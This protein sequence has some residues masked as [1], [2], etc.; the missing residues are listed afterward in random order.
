[1]Y[2]GMCSRV[3]HQFGLLTDAMKEK[4]IYDDSAIFFFS[5]HG[6]YTGDYGIVEKSQNSF[7][8]SISSV[9]FII[10]PPSVYKVS[11]RVTDALAELIDFSATVFEMTGIDPGYDS[12]GRSLLP[13][14]AGDT[15]V[16]REAVF[17]EEGAD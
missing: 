8:D 5:D 16:H 3:D 1:M 14:I 7:E 10:K 6:D 12:F 15:D 9:P 2:Y 4:K 11:P 13:L 17:C